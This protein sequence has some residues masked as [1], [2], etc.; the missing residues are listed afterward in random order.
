MSFL[1]AKEATP[2]SHDRALPP[3]SHVTLLTIPSH[4]WKKP[5]QRGSW[6]RFCDT[7]LSFCE[8]SEAEEEETGS[9]RRKWSG[10]EKFEKRDRER[11]VGGQRNCEHSNFP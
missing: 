4:V 8:V 1:D 3:T 6:N 2:E 7:Q 9:G 11:E 5:W 10:P